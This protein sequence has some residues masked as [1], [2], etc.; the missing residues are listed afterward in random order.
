MPR[1]LAQAPRRGADCARSDRAAPE[2][3]R[4]L[5][6]AARRGAA[7]ARRVEEAAAAELAGRLRAVDGGGGDARPPASPGA[8][9]PARLRDDG[10]GCLRVDHADVRLLL[11]AAFRAG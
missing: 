11:A 10:A 8:D 7:V 6:R 9:A 4:D 1:T 3:V 2:P 5:P